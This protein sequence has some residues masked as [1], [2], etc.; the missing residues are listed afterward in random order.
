MRKAALL[1]VT[2]LVGVAAG[3]QASSS[4]VKVLTV[5]E[6]L[7]DVSRYA[8]AVVAVVGQLERSVSLIDHYEYL[9]QGRCQHPV[10]THGHTWSNRIQI[11]TAWEEGMPKPPSDS[12]SLAPAVVAEKLSL[13]QKTT[14]LGVHQEPRFTTEGQSIRYS[15]T[16]TVPNEWAV[17]Y[18][19]IVRSS[20]L[21]EDCGSKGC[22]GVDVPLVIIANE[23]EVHSLPGGGSSSRK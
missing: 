5:C 14:T 19:R 18:G 12:P 3:Q 20:R 22:G 15:H 13:V 10:V 2:V 21:D 9:S 11:W 16:A 1:L 6:V 17:A 7:A 8:D 4:R 23:Q